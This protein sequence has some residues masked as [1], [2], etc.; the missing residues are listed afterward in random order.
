MLVL[1]DENIPLMTVTALRSAGHD[2]RDIRSS[3]LQG[4]NDDDLWRL[5]Q[6]GRRLLITTDKGFVRFR[7]DAHNGILII[8][9]RQ[10]NR[11]TIH[12]RILLAMTQHP[13]DR[14]PGMVVVMRDSVKSVSK[15][16]GLP[17]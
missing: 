9:L 12:D 14:W 15:S 4:L 1:V 17:G 16:R 2:V 5:A 13:A 11:K 7:D 10:P 6:E 3:E 8:L